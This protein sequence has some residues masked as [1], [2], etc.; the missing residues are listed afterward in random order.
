MVALNEALLPVGSQQD[1]IRLLGQRR[2]PGACDE[3]DGCPVFPGQPGHLFQRRVPP[4]AGDDQQ[5]VVLCQSRRKGTG[6]FRDGTGHAPLAQAAKLDRGFQRDAQ[7][8]AGSGHFHH[9]GRVQAGQR[10][11]QLVRIQRLHRGPY[12]FLFVDEEFLQD[13]PHPVRLGRRVAFFRLLLLHHIPR[14]CQLELAVTLKAK[15]VA[16]PGHR[17]FRGLALPRQLC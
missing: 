8:M 1:M 16:Q 12:F 7:V 9:M 10:C 6:L 5:Q 17:G 14:K 2:V 4:G 11:P 13:A 3:E 15:F